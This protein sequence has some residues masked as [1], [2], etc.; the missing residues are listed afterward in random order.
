MRTRWQLGHWLTY[1]KLA[2]AAYLPGQRAR[3]KLQGKQPHWYT[4]NF[5]GILPGN[6]AEERISVTDD[7]VFVALMGNAL[8]SSGGSQGQNSA[9]GF[10]LQFFDAGRKQRFEYVMAANDNLVGTAKHPFFLRYMY[11]LTPKT[12][13]LLRVQNASA[14]N[15]VD[16]QVVF[17]GC[18]E[19]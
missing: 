7:F 8:I 18:C 2:S 9:D 15:T 14:V 6:N 11:C 16:I 13:M 3:L 12:P 4:F 10:N 19:G 1:R 5:P 17:H